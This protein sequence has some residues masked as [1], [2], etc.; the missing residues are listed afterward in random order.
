MRRASSTSWEDWVGRVD[1]GR[2]SNRHAPLPAVTTESTGSLAPKCSV[3][4]SLCNYGPEPSGKY[5]MQHMV[6]Q[7]GERGECYIA[8]YHSDK[9]L[10]FA[11]L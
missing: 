10:H 8:S 4:A 7:H 3:R 5:L 2:R 11:A 1:R 9:L 6:E